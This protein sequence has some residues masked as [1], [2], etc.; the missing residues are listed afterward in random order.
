MDVYGLNCEWK[1]ER[2]DRKVA[3]QE[4]KELYCELRPVKGKFSERL[5]T[6]GNM[7]ASITYLQTGSSDRKVSFINFENPYFGGGQELNQ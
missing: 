3:P 2:K 6:T 5:H 1:S 4:N 7:L